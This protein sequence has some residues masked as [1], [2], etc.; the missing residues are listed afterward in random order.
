METFEWTLVLLVGAV[1]LAALARRIHAPYPSLLALGG[2]ALALLPSAP[3]FR[4]DPELTLALFVAP[5]LLD[6]AY[7]A[8]LRDLRANWIPVTCL[9]LAAVG[10]TTVAVAWLAH[11]LAPTMPWGAAIALGAIVAPPDAAA[12]SAILRQLRLP[13]RLL[14]ILEGESLLNDASALLIY[15]LAV[16]AVVSGGLEAREVVPLFALAAAGSIVVGYFLAR[17]YLRLTQNIADTSSAIVLQFAGTFGVW[18]LAERIGLSAIVTVVV[19]AV[20]LARDAPRLVPARQRIPSYAVWETVVFILNVLAFVL[21]GLQLRPILAA[22]DPV[23]RT[24]YLQIGAAVLGVVVL[25]RFAWVFLYYGVARL[26][27]RLL[28]PGRWPGSAQPTVRS[29]TVVGWCGMRGIVTLA[30]AYALPFTFPYRDLILLCAFCVVVGTLVVQ[31]LTLRPLILLLALTDDR[32]VER[33]VRLTCERMARTGLAV[34]DADQSAEA[35][36]LRREF[37]AQLQDQT[38]PG[39]SS[40]VQSRYDALRARIVAAQRGVLLDM[41]ANGEIGDDAF[42]RI[43]GLLDVAEVNA[44][45]RAE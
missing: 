17:L 16:L 25:A 37:E 36:V 33:E 41:R 29:A 3:E 44:N 43:E 24:E 38:S 9:V 22:L 26:K 34:L 32:P 21:I 13:H 19:Y 15:R 40:G 1:G 35:Q 27:S 23:E 45:G 6:A 42:H 5:V 12:A 11:A 39:I 8:S 2:V 4:L 28:G 18:I 31:G 20:T 10:V 30:A 7:D 14:V